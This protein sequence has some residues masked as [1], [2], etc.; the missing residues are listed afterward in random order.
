[1]EPVGNHNFLVAI[2]KSIEAA[3]GVL[4]QHVE[5]EEVV[6]VLIGVEGTE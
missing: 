6:L 3:V 5:I 2:V 4:L 1:M